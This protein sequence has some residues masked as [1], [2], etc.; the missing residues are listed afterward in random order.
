M[1]D[2]S[3]KII[4]AVIAYSPTILVCFSIG[5]QTMYADTKMKTNNEPV[6]L[7]VLRYYLLQSYSTTAIRRVSNITIDTTKYL[8][9]CIR[10][11]CIL[12]KV[13][14]IDIASNLPSV[15]CEYIFAQG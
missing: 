15:H 3:V 2:P 1:R 12:D 6:V 10:W 7:N 13:A 4:C 14:S 8:T 5:H 11:I 9:I